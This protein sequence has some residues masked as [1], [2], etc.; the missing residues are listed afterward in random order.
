MLHFEE[1]Y[2]NFPFSVRSE[3]SPTILICDGDNIK[4]SKCYRFVLDTSN[5]NNIKVQKCSNNLS[6]CND[7]NMHI[8][9]RV[10]SYL[11]C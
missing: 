10:F 5:G 3:N 1:T 8:Q 7:N 11:I 9:V 6:N 2:I 4:N